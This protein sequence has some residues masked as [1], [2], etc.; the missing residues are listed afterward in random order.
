MW[1]LQLSNT[2]DQHLA[3]SNHAGVSPVAQLLLKDTQ[4][5]QRSLETELPGQTSS[6]AG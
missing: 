4:L 2:G 6:L 3:Q 1:Q 5:L